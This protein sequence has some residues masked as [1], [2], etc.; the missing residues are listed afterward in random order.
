M[1]ETE[2]LG[3]AGTVTAVVL[4]LPQLVRLART[5]N[6]EGLSL[7]AWQAFLAVNLGWTAHGIAIGQAPQVVASALSLLSTVPILYL[8]SRQLKRSFL[9]TLA[10]G[11]GLAALT[12]LIDQLFGS[13]AYGAVA[14]IPAVLANAGQSVALVR[15]RHVDG[16][17]VLFLILAVVNQMIWLAWA[18]LVPDTGTII[19][20]TTTGIIALF[21]L[22]WY[23]A[24]VLGLPPMPSCQAA[25]R[26]PQRE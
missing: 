17:S 2:I 9:L 11:L 16:V 20:A 19:A 25:P 3:W 14:I 13:G 26:S 1:T 7:P 24:R 5:R 10:P 12:V 15:A 8:M 21:N 4:G 22:A 18:L 6:V 23:P